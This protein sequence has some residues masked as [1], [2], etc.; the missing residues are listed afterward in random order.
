[1]KQIYLF[2]FCLLFLVNLSYA[3]FKYE[4]PIYVKNN[5][6]SALTNV[7]VLI[8]FNTQV[9][10]G[11]GW[12][13]ADGK[14]IV[15]TSACGGVTYLSHFV[16]AYL[17]TDSTRLWVKI[18]SIGANDSTLIY[19]YYGN[20]TATNTS[21][22]NVFDGPH[23]ATDS[24][25]VTSSNTVSNCQRGFKFT[26]TEDILVAYFGKRTPNATQRYLTLFDFTSQAI[27]AQI[28]VDAG[29]VGAYNY[30]LLP[31]PL[32]LK[33][34]QA[35]VMELFNG[36][37]DMYYFGV[38]TQVGQ[39]LTWGEM[40]YQNSC[41]QNTF[42]TSIIANQHYGCPD[43]WYYTKQN[44]TPAPTN[45]ILLPADTLAPAIPLNLTGAPSNQTVT[46]KWRK[47]TE[48]DMYSYK[49]YRNTVNNPATA[50]LTATVIHPDTVSVQGSLVNGTP[51][52]FWVKAVDR[53]CSLKE[54]GFST[55]VAVT[56]V[57]VTSEIEIPKAFNLY[58]NIPNPFN[59]ETE[60][61]FDIPKKSFVTLL[62]YDITGKEI[63][64]LINE[65]KDA[66]SYSLRWDGK[67]L[68]SG[69]YFY[70]ITAGNFT[71]IKKMILIK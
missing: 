17:N 66:G 54:S 67:E 15:F 3:Q 60:I 56:P 14:D 36:T 44:I 71:S 46:L 4:N 65:V 70:K 40:R 8:K 45:R 33:S 6:A 16:E 41:T 50:T 32:W 25:V 58:Q 13:Q 52:Y 34:G 18:P 57:S 19:I 47:N 42:P 59:P 2:L 62:V 29:T 49:V 27:L 35:Y 37:G 30:N 55:V 64:K 48:F 43:F 26:P 5:T 24:V 21:T 28:Q 53:Y 20:P 68:S 10:I 61:K 23:S 1:M 39:H 38:S 69:T 63:S 12:M 31:T 9:P 11:A 51:Y 22:L 7:Q